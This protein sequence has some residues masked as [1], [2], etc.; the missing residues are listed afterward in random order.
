M[1]LNGPSTLAVHGG[2]ERRK[3]E[4]SLTTPIFQTATYP[5]RSMGERLAY[6]AGEIARITYGRYGNPTQRAA[7]AKLAALEGGEAALLFAS[8][9]A[10][11]TTC[12]LTFLSRGDHALFVDQCYWQTRTFASRF[13]PRLG[14]ETGFIPRWSPGEVERHVKGNTRVIF[15]EVP[16]NPHLH[17]PDLEELVAAGRACGAVVIVDST[18]AT[19]INLRPLKFGVDLVVHS[20]T[21]YLGGHNDLLA[22]AVVGDEERVGAVKETQ[23][24]L[25]GIPDP[26]G[27]YL[28]LRGMKTLALRVGRQNETAMAVARFLEA[29]PKVRRVWYPGLACHPHHEVAKRY[30]TG[31]GGVVS[32]ELAATAEET[33]RFID[34]LH[35]P[36]L[37]SSF[38]GVESLVE[39]SAF[40]SFCAFAP[41]E[42]RALGI[43]DSLV[44]LSVGVEDPDDLIADLERA[45]DEALS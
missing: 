31:F 13:L 37:A 38:G 24:Y 35:I 44:R 6:N 3:P 28:L 17:V 16:T 1:S 8:G 26:H 22:G 29:H 23:A 43:S 2:E 21:K 10:A 27:A 30:L 15:A 45:L 20:A 11:V 34:A 25:G 36:Y 41:E 40:T 4:H 39:Q 14:V 32:F 19:P 7:E 12:L 9:M 5:F 33:G 42:R 18:M